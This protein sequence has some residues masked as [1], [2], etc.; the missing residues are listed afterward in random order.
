LLGEGVF[1]G[2]TKKTAVAKCKT[3][4]S[5]AVLDANEFETLRTEH[6][7]VLDYLLVF[8][9]KKTNERLMESGK[10]L[11]MIYDIIT[12]I[13]EKERENERGFCEVL[14]HIKNILGFEFI[15]SVDTHQTLDNILFYRFNTRFPSVYPINSRGDGELDLLQK[16]SVF[17]SS[18]FMGTLEN[19]QAQ[20]VELR[21]QGRICGYLIFGKKADNPF[22]QREIRIIHHV[23][24]LLASLVHAMQ[25]QAEQKAAQ[26]L[27]ENTFESKRNFV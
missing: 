1:F 14:S 3:D 18:P 9:L 16:E 13:G 21:I 8:A 26:R 19:E 22:L 17:P 27:R 7:F 4:L 25:V 5:V 23:S 2:K 6:P 10:E 24:K 11:A 20:S 15:L 12:N